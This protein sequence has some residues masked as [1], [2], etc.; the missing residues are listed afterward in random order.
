MRLKFLTVIVVRL[1]SNISLI[2]ELFVSRLPSKG[3]SNGQAGRGASAGPKM[4]F[5]TPQTGFEQFRQIQNPR[6]TQHKYTVMI[7]QPRKKRN[8]LGVKNA[9]LNAWNETFYNL[10]TEKQNLFKMVYINRQTQRRQTRKRNIKK[11]Q[12]LHVFGLDV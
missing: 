2:R 1:Q 3:S 6:C 11:K 5:W 8:R 12:K 7:R 9:F 4:L 10:F